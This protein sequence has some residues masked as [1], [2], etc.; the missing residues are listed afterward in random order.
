MRPH[1]PGRVCSDRP[2]RFGVSGRDEAARFGCDSVCNMPVYR[3]LGLGRDI[4][5]GSPQ[6][7]GKSKKE[8]IL[9]QK[10]QTWSG[11]Y[12]LIGELLGYVADC[13]REGGVIGS[14]ALGYSLP[15]LG[16]LDG[17]LG[18][19]AVLAGRTGAGRG[20]GGRS[21]GRAGGGGGSAGLDAHHYG[22]LG[23]I[24]LLEILG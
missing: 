6:A 8:K 20:R 14:A 9:N 16:S 2:P 23:R 21:A 5:P 7:Q 19:R 11:I 3:F 18:G 1:R 10:S 15:A 13:H 4:Q 17:D 24:I 12:F 22:I